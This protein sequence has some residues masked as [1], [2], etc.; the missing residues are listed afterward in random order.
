[1]AGGLGFFFEPQEDGDLDHDQGR[2]CDQSRTAC[3]TGH[4]VTNQ[5]QLRAN[6]QF[7]TRKLHLGPKRS[8][9]AFRVW[10]GGVLLIRDPFV[11]PAKAPSPSPVSRPRPRNNAAVP[12]YRPG[13]PEGVSDAAPCCAAHAPGRGGARLVRDSTSPPPG[14]PLPPHTNTPGLRHHP[15]GATAA[16]SNMQSD[17]PSDAAQRQNNCLI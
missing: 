6:V 5:R 10:A 9:S 8:L 14:S 11:T 3:R 15:A 4:Q 7:C 12:D 2:G 13:A 16:Q 1:M 17:Y